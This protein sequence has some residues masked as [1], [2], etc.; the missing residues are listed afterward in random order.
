MTHPAADDPFGN[1]LDSLLSVLDVPSGET[2]THDPYGALC[3]MF[4]ICDA[5]Y[6][7]DPN[8]VP[9]DWGFCAAPSGGLDYAECA[10]EHEC[11][12]HS[13]GECSTARMMLLELQVNLADPY[14]DAFGRAAEEALIELGNAL[15]PDALLYTD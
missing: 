1:A 15:N 7:L 12:T 10:G 13:S 4:T 5:L 8:S 2:T 3:A 14:G 9:A 6:W 11:E